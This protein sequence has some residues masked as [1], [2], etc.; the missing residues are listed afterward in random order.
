MIENSKK[1]LVVFAAA[2]LFAAGCSVSA[3]GQIPCVD[4]SSCPA[5][6]PSCKSGFCVEG[7]TTATASAS[8]LGVPGKAAAD[9]LK[10]PA[11]VQVSG[12]ANWGVKSFA[13]AG[14]GKRFSPA[15]GATG[16]VFNITVDTT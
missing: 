7:G 10:G 9:P 2:A 6:Y 16:P 1:L 4:D 14:G 12:R 15:A 5:D 11:T 3:S 8:I 13:L